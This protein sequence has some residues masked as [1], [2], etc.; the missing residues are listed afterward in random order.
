M[1]WGAAVWE[2]ERKVVLWCRKKQG[3]LGLW[4]ETLQDVSL[5]DSVSTLHPGRSWSLLS[6]RPSPIPTAGSSPALTSPSS[7]LSWGR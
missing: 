3:S 6:A 2:V 4:L 1:F 7:G 5:T